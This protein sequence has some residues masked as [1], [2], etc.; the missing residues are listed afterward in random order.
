MDSTDQSASSASATK[1]KSPGSSDENGTDQSSTAG[2]STSSEKKPNLN[3]AGHQQDASSFECNICL[4]TAK[5]PV[6]SMCGHL[7]CWPCL[8]QWLETR[9]T[10]Q[11][12]PVCKSAI[13]KEKVIPVYNRG[14]ENKDPRDKV[15]PRPQGQRT[16]PSATPMFNFGDGG[17][18][19]LQFSFGIGAF[20]FTFFASTFNLGE[21]RPSAPAAGTRQHEEETFLSKVFVWIAVFFLIWLF[22][23]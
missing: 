9:P 8:H 22:L 5:D 17:N 3:Q 12:C 19:G 7:F 1:Q 4:D 20:P 13:S 23:A 18:G 21:Q 11:V 14:G 2:P 10:R 15:P 16:E 6:I